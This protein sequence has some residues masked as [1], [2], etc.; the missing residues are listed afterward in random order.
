MSKSWE[1]EEKL[2]NVCGETFTVYL[3]DDPSFSDP[4]YFIVHGIYPWFFTHSHFKIFGPF[5][6]EWGYVTINYQLPCI[7]GGRNNNVLDHFWWSFS[8]EGQNGGMV[9]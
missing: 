2:R 6:R 4:W 7:Y 9:V 3:L 1:C 5:W 8:C